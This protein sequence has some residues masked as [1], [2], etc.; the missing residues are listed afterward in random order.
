MVNVRLVCLLVV[1]L[2][3]TVG[4]TTPF[5]VKSAALAQ[6]ASSCTTDRTLAGQYIVTLTKEYMKGIPTVAAAS[7]ASATA[8]ASSTRGN[9][10]ATT[11]AATY[12]TH[13]SQSGTGRALADDDFTVLR[14]FSSALVGA[15][16]RLA[17]PVLNSVLADPAVD[18]VEVDCVVSLNEPATDK[19]VRHDAAFS[20]MATLP[21]TQSGAWWGLDQLDMAGD[22]T[23][24]SYGAA[25]G[26]GVRICA[27]QLGA[28]PTTVS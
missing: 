18:L 24:Y 8:A 5:D 9:D 12:L 19:K 7:T 26:D 13:S 16:V 25:T 20:T 28:E 1:V 14:T 2:R 21:G 15:T 11:W 27:H 23:T 17:D 22:D 3:P 10:P 4:Q 6:S